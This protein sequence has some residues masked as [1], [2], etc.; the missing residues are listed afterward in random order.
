MVGRSSR[1]SLWSTSRA[2]TPSPTM[3]ASY[4]NTGRRREIVSVTTSTTSPNAVLSSPT[5][6]TTR[7]SQPSRMV[8]RARHLSIG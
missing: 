7:A 6:R 1:M 5:R 4:A 2:A 3:P 8:P